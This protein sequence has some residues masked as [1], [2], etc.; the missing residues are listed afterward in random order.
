MLAVGYVNFNGTKSSIQ[1]VGVKVTSIVAE[2]ARVPDERVFV[3][4]VTTAEGLLT[5][6]CTS[7]F[8]VEKVMVLTP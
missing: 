5:C 7:A 8:V 1:E 6:N 3:K 4:F 2:G